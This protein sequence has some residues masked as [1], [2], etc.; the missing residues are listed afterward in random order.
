MGLEPRSTWVQGSY[1]EQNIAQRYKPEHIITLHSQSAVC[2]VS[3]HNGQP[4]HARNTVRDSSGLDRQDGRARRQG[5]KST[6]PPRSCHAH[7]DRSVG[8]A[9]TV[10]E[11]SSITA[12]YISEYYEASGKPRGKGLKFELTFA[13][14]RL[15]MCKHQGLWGN[16]KISSV[17]GTH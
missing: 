14:A 10:P 17:N 5:S 13:Q 16:N 1:R 11:P 7:P 15:L 4:R 9:D 12:S 3:V 2:V 6:R 8:Q